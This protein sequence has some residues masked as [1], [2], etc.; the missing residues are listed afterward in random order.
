MTGSSP[1]TAA[2][3]EPNPLAN[4]MMNWDIVQLASQL[5]V[6]LNLPYIPES[7]EQKWIEWILTRV[8]K[9]VP[10]DLVAILVDAADGLD[11]EERKAAENKLVALANRLIDIPVLPEPVEESLIRP[12][13]RQLLTYAT[14]GRALTMVR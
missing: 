7:V 13:V 8:V 14:E 11:T 1:A 4:P 2:S 12:I 5:N 10:S 3:T 6:E 9:V